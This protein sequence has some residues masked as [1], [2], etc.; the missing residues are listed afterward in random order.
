MLSR[1][2]CDKKTVRKAWIERKVVELTQKYI[3][4]DDMI[5][6]IA[7][8]VIALHNTDN[9]RIPYLQKQ[10]DDVQKRINNLLNAIEEGLFNTSA[11]ERLDG[12]ETAK[13]DL[14][15]SIAKEKIEKPPLTKEQVVFWISKFKDGDIENPTYRKNLVDIFV[16]SVYLYEDILIID[17]N[18]KDGTQTVSLAELEAAVESSNSEKAFNPGDNVGSYLVDNSPPRARE[19]SVQLAVLGSVPRSV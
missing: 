7:D 13:S 2:L 12:L 6:L 8:R 19:P 9:S 18:V 3:L 15:I 17:Y 10:L 5:D 11:K 16:N 4:Q 14:E 1:K